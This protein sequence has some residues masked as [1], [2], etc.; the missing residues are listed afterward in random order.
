MEIP[1]KA[2][3]KDVFE[4]K[5]P[6]YNRDKI[7]DRPIM[8]VEIAHEENDDIDHQRRHVVEITREWIKIPFYMNLVP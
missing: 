1:P 2:L 5:D 7:Y 3:E 6:L 8:N 4:I